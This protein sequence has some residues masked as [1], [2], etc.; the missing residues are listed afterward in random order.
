M[1]KLYY[2]VEKE[3]HQVG[4]FEE[5]TGYRMITVYEIEN[6]VPTKFFSSESYEDENSIEA[7]NNY[8]SDNGYGDET[9]ELVQ[10]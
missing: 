8:L 4:E 3:T 6:N 10:L 2:T 1:R 9:F 7:I 5:I